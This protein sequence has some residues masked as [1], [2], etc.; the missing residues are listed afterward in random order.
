MQVAK[1]KTKKLERRIKRLEKALR[2]VEKCNGVGA[3][4]TMGCVHCFGVA[5]EALLRG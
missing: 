5:R 4:L 3:D 2:V 1:E